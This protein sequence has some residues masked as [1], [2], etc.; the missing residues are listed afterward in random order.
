MNCDTYIKMILNTQI[1]DFNAV[2]RE[3]TPVPEKFK[4]F[5]EFKQIWEP[6]FMLESY[7]SLTCMDGSGTKA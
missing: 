1:Y 6:L 4:N 3:Y 7:Y 2:R 5:E